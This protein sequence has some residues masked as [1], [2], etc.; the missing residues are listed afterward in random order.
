M[1]FKCVNLWSQPYKKRKFQ[2]FS[3]LQREIEAE[4]WKKAGKM[5]CPFCQQT[6][7]QPFGAL[8]GH[9]NS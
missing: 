9:E 8:K 5:R 7:H 1:A 6:A 2:N 3:H 4:R